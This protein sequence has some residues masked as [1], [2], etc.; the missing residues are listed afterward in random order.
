M[1]SRCAYE[2]SRGDRVVVGFKK[3]T[4]FVHEEGGLYSLRGR[5]ARETRNVR[6]NGSLGATA[7]SCS[8]NLSNPNPAPALAGPLLDVQMNV[9]TLCAKSILPVSKTQI[10]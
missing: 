4:D 6:H 2:S 3:T 8:A 7:V 9:I 5:E 10:K 1:N